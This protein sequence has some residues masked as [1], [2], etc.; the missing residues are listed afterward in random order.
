MNRTTRTILIVGAV[1]V[2]IF[3]I[4]PLVA[5][6]LWGGSRYGGGW[7]MMG[8]GMMGGFGFMGLM[9]IFWIVILGLI[10]WA[11]AG[12]WRGS[13]GC[14]HHD[15]SGSDS[16]LDILKRRYASGELSKAEYEEKKKDLA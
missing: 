5:G 12:G 14:G 11:V 2:G 7:G 3:V 1:I 6:S 16:A 8:P 13:C 15:S 10:I 4:L 9:P